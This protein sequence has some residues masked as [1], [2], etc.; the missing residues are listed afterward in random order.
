MNV[1]ASSY[2]HL[3]IPIPLMLLP[4]DLILEFHRER[5][6]ISETDVM[7]LIQFLRKEIE[8]RET[9]LGFL[10]EQKHSYISV[11]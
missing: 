11:Y 2:G 8:C 9:S 3:L 10:R 4:H 6:E 1:T 7:E 5:K